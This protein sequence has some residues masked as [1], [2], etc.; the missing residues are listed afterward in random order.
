MAALSR[1]GIY[2]DPPALFVAFHRRFDD[3]LYARTVVQSR[4]YRLSGCDGSHE[5]TRHVILFAE[6]IAVRI[7]DGVPAGIPP[8]AIRDRQFMRRPLAR[9]RAGD[10]LDGVPVIQGIQRAARSMKFP[11]M[12]LAEGRAFV[13]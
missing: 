10:A 3:L 9:L 5:S 7:V 8:D 1:N 2:L 4:L 11:V 6:H 13:A 12:R